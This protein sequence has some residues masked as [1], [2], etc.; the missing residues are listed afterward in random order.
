[1]IHSPWTVAWRI[2]LAV[3]LVLT[4]T[5]GAEENAGG[6]P[7]LIID[8]A[9]TTDNT[10]L[11]GLM[12]MSPK[13]S[14]LS[15]LD[16]ARNFS[17]WQA[18][19][20]DS[21]DAPRQHT[22]VWLKTA[23]HNSSDQALIRWLVVEPWR[24]N[25]ADA[26]LLDPLSNKQLHQYSTGLEVPLADRAVVNGKTLIPITLNAGESQQLYLHIYSD[27]LPF[28]SIKS[29]EPVAY[30]ESIYE[31]RI[32]QMALFAAIVTLLVILA[33]QLNLSLLSTGV[34]LLVA[35][36][37]QVEKDGFF[38]NYLFSALEGYSFNLRYSGWIFTELLFLISSILL[39]GLSKQ[40]PW[41]L[42]MGVVGAVTLTLVGLTFVMDN[43]MIRS[44]GIV[45]MTL[46]LISWL[47]MVR[48]ALRIPHFGQKTLLALLA[49]YWGMSAFILF[50]YTF[51]L[52]YTAAF[53]GTRIY[54]VIIVALALM[55]TYSRQHKLQLKRA[56]KALNAHQVQHRRALEQAVIDRTAELHNALETAKKSN[57]AKV[58]FLAQITHDLRAPL[59]AIIG[60]AE[61]QAAGLVNVQ[62]TNNIIQNRAAY[63]KNMISSLLDYS[64]DLS[65]DHDQPSD[66]YLSAFLDNLVNQVHFLANKQ[67]NRFQL[68][69]E[70]EL[71]TII[72]CNHTY[73]QRV[74][75]NLLDNA[76]KYTTGGD[77]SLTISIGQ[78][79]Q[80]QSA[81]VF[82]VR[83]TGSGMTSD[84]L[85]SNDEQF[86]TRADDS[87]GLG[88]H[89]C[90]ELTARMGGSLVLTSELGVGTVAKC[91]IP[92]Q[93]GD[94]HNVSSSLPVTQ[95]LLPR[96]DAQG[97]CAWIIEDSLLIRELL[98][99]ELT[100]LGFNTQLAVSTEDFIHNAITEPL[101]QSS[102]L[103]APAIIVT[104]YC[105]PGA[106]GLA[107]LHAARE[108]WPAVPVILL[109]AIQ[110]N[111]PQAQETA[112]VGFSAYLS[113]PIDLLALRLALA[114]LCTLTQIR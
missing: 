44:L 43:A 57:T 68:L 89:I 8:L 99:A 110:R 105:L 114:K 92:Y 80:S 14:G 91:V 97:L 79:E 49:I 15:Q 51:N 53:S 5:A 71:P 19:G 62:D 61:L 77:I 42:F 16:E 113:K 85:E 2:L 41:R 34:W 27:S 47:C 107:V 100:E 17:D 73:L 33:L 82:Q 18:I 75:L 88:L 11:T 4:P 48:P 36:F 6:E 95:D 31:S 3:I 24:V 102:T 40:T 98:D 78:D 30:S 21:V 20:P 81:L 90:F 13:N 38:S 28:I 10:E 108:Q 50:S 29:W 25:R 74:L 65:A 104:D 84:V 63:M 60:C 58:N 22:R 26:F 87:T 32:F 83:D 7:L 46:Y 54:V 72:R 94:E 112:E 66:I 93:L 45:V 35:F 1:M 76:A 55:I 12:L 39:L 106:S 86:L 9:A 23:L 96:F 69:I 103:P 111:I 70:S 52:Y 67:E 101:S 59:T 109:S 64:Q 56:K 37:Y